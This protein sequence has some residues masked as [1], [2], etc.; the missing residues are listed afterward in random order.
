MMPGKLLRYN[1]K[2]SRQVDSLE[3][4]H[5]KPHEQERWIG[6]QQV[7]LTHNAQI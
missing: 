2:R 7:E 6:L 5:A 3:K 4:L 1:R